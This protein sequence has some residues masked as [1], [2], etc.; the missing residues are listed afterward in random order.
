MKYR[1]LARSIYDS[2]TAVFSEG[3]RFR[4]VSEK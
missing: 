3:S 4:I 2:K 1:V